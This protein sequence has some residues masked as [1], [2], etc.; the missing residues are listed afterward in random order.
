MAFSFIGLFLIL[1]LSGLHVA[2]ILLPLVCTV[3]WGRFPLHEISRH[4]A[5]MI[6]IIYK[7]ASFLIS[8]VIVITG[9]IYVSIKLIM[10]LCYHRNT[11]SFPVFGCKFNEF[12]SFVQVFLLT[13]A[14]KLLAL[15]VASYKKKQM[16]GL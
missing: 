11:S 2:G 8:A 16:K 14:I 9:C 15:S 6:N 13:Y 10:S 12:H 5:E 7:N 1:P 4:A 3:A